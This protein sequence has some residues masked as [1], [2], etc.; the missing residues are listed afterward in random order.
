MD[1][2]YYD[3]TTFFRV[4]DGFMTQWGIHPDPRVSEAWREA[5]IDDDPVEASNTRGRI[6]FATAGPDTRTTQLFINY[7]DNSRLDQMGFAPF[8]EVVEGM[9]VV[10]ALYS[11]YGEGAPRGKG[12]DQGRIQ[13]KGDVYLAEFPELDR[14]VR[15][16][17]LPR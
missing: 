12:P 14:I 8:G 10:D 4:I 1:A 7:I 3:G 17:I 16:S 6:T 13:A 9:E 15:A 2:G 5:R 11:D